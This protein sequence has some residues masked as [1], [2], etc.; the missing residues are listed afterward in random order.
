M[1]VRDGELP[2]PAGQRPA[3]PER[4]CRK[5]NAHARD[6]EVAAL[7]AEAK[8]EIMMQRFEGLQ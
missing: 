7:L 3:L 5:Q 4:N 1:K 6:H 8:A 2:S